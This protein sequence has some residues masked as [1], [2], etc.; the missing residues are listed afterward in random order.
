MAIGREALHR[1]HLGDGLLDEVIDH[2]ETAPLESLLPIPH[3]T[4]MSGP[5]PAGIGRTSRESIRDRRDRDLG[6]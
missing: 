1:N 4:K 3:H 6:G 5:V 2:P